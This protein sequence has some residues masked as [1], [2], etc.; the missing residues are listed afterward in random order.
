[1]HTLK[2]ERY[3]INGEGIAIDENGKIVFVP[4]AIKDEIVSCDIE[5]TNKDFSVAKLEKIIKK[6][7]LRCEPAC[8]YFY[9]CGGCQLQHIQYDE[10]LKIKKQIVLN[11]IKKIAK[12]NVEV[13]DVIANPNQ[14]FYRNH[15]NFAVAHDGRLGF[16]KYNSH[17]VLEVKKCYIANK[18]I[19]D[20]ITIL[21]SYFFD[22]NLK[23]Y[24][25]NLKIGQIKH[26]DIKY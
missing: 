9:E 18:I 5:K 6:S 12:L 25:Y 4:Y 3:G 15:I 14:F 17:N 10:Q 22:N 13:N 7:D 11:N 16:F 19:N 2:I 24:D 8:P 23:G 1:M 20:C 26:V 21:K